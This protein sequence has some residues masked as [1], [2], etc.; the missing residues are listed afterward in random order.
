MIHLPAGHELPSII[1][2][3]VSV[4]LSEVGSLD[5]ALRAVALVA[6]LGVQ[7]VYWLWVHPVNGFWT[8]GQELGAFGSGFF[9]LRLGRGAGDQGSA[10]T[11]TQLRGRWESGHAVRAALALVS[12]VAL[13]VALA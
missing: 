2:T 12:V 11:W 4:A 3:A 10:P 5:F 9:A 8:L 13:V 1:L 7:V 6:L